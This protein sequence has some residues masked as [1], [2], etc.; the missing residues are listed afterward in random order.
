VAVALAGAGVVAAVDEIGAGLE[1]VLADER[2]RSSAQGV[3][4][5]MRRLPPAAEFLRG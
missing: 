3:A 4:D 5:E 2:F 1:R